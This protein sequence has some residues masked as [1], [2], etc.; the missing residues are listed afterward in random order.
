MEDLSI[1]LTFR[2]N[3]FK[4]IY[5]RDNNKIFFVY[6]PAKK[7]VVRFLIIVAI[8]IIIH[9]SSFIYPS[10]NGL[11][12][13]CS[14]GLVICLIQLIAEGFV[15]F[16]WKQKIQHYINELLNSSYFKLNLFQNSFEYVRDDE[17]VI[18]KWDN[19]KS[20]K[21]EDDYASLSTIDNTDYLFPAKS[22]QP[23]E[24]EKLI[25]IIKEKLR[26]SVS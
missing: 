12:Y 20:A 22:M 8:S 17:T 16:S 26:G 5:Y 13:F 10:I 9:F 2:E 1:E 25:I 18:E 19:I 4:E 11:L 24:Y 21:I 7:I 15:Y 23:E 14:L 3:D 6:P